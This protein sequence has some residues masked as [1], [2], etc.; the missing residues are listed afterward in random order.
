V[1]N[2]FVKIACMGIVSCPECALATQVGLGPIAQSVRPGRTAATAAVLTGHSNAN[3][4]AVTVA[5]T[6]TTQSAKSDVM[7]PMVIVTPPRRAD[8]N[9]VGK[10]KIAPNASHSGTASTAI[11]STPGSAIADRDFL[12]RPAATQK[13]EMVTGVSGLHG[14]NALATAEIR[15]GTGGGSAI[16]PSP[17]VTENTAH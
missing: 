7:Q 6:A 9:R 15:P 4:T 2:L 12:V 8:A 11:A 13:A 16:T 3:V 10:A 1:I 17:L 14:Q 5:E